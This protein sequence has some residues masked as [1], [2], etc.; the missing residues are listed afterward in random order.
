MHKYF[1]ALWELI[2][3]WLCG[4]CNPAGPAATPQRP[5]SRPAAVTRTAARARVRRQRRGTQWQ[6]LRV[7]VAQTRLRVTVTLTA[8]ATEACLAVPRSR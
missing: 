5:A 8:S 3:L 4:N 1:A 2:F 6:R 7:A